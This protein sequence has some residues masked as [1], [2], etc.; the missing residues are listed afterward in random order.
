MEGLLRV[1]AKKALA[2]ELSDIP[3]DVIEIAKLGITDFFG[4]AYAGTDMPVAQNVRAYLDT[5]GMRQG[6]AVLLG[7]HERAD[8]IAAS[9]FNATAGH[10][11]DF[12]DVSWATIGHPSVVVAP[13]AIACGQALQA[14]GA[15][16]L[17]AYIL[18]VELMHQIARWTMPQLSERGWH[19]TPAN[20]V[21]GTATV[22][23]LLLGLNEEQFTNALAIAATRAFGVRANFGSQTKALHAG[24]CAQ[25]GIECA[26]LAQ[27]GITGRDNAIEA[28]DGYAQCLADPIDAENVKVDFCEFW[29]LRET[30]LVIKQY[31][32]CSGTHPTLDVWDD[33]LNEHPLSADDI[34]S[35]YSGVS[36]LGPRELSC[37]HPINC[38]Q[39]KFS[40]E[41]AI[42]ARL[43][44]GEVGITTFTDEKVLDPRI[45][46]FMK[47]V[48]MRIDPELEKLGFIGTA[49]IRMRITLTN[50]ETIALSNDLA[51]GNP[52]KP[53][54]PAKFEKKF[55]NCVVPG[56]GTEKAQAWWTTLQT[57]ETAC[58]EAIASL[59][60]HS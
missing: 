2:T 42:A 36:L 32:C 28:L 47:K 11:L 26:L 5:I 22:A 49:P 12:D 50:G 59:G 18:G 56:A 24:L 16:V 25:S 35:I 30:G 57:L 7:R 29:D 15:A 21:F 38:V 54:T 55:M 34:D 8:M 13:C 58:V 20:G 39:A 44:H 37:H 31:P 45:Q 40:L 41:Y 53:L 60:A 33:F 4:V 52:E 9:L 1:L 43:I 6:P 10:A 48:D 19:T 14:D 17:R 23:A 27:H 46:A 51:M 3:T